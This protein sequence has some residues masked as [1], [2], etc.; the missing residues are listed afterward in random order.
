MNPNEQTNLNSPFR[1]TGAAKL[2]NYITGKWIEGDG[3]G[4]LLLDAVTGEPVAS[5]TT[6]GL[7]FKSILSYARDIG[8]PAL[9][10]MAFHERG[11]M[12]KALANYLL[13]TVPTRF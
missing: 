11:K 1:G 8:N 2:R 4:Q 3:D 5:A 12:L 9:R 7:D 6:K 13:S 10:K